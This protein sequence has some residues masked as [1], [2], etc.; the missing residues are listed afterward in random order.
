MRVL[1]GA[2]LAAIA[3]GPVSPASDQLAVTLDAQPSAR[4][5]AVVS[6]ATIVAYDASAARSVSYR[7]VRSD[8]SVSRTGRLAF[9]GEGAV[10]QSVADTWT[11][12]GSAPWV[13]L[14]IVAPQRVRSQRLRVASRCARGVVAATR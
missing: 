3:T 1:A 14:E 10:A 8:G 11:P 7:F 9:S 2:L 4:S 5:C 12:R 13:A 6:R